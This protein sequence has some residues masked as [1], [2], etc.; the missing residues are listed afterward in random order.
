[1]LVK[2]TELGDMKYSTNVTRGARNVNPLRVPLRE[3][4]IEFLLFFCFNRIAQPLVFVVVV[5]LIFFM[6]IVFC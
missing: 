4:A 5:K 3:P 1:M 6:I 2:S